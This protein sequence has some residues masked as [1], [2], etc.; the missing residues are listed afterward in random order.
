MRR[1]Y[2]AAVLALWFGVA[3]PSISNARAAPDDPRPSGDKPGEQPGARPGEKPAGDKPGDL[4]KSGQPGAGPEGA[5]PTTTTPAGPTGP[6]EVPAARPAPKA[7]APVAAV[8]ARAVQKE[9]GLFLETRLRGYFNLMIVPLPSGN[10]MYTTAAAPGFVLGYKYRR[11][12]LG[13]AVDFM[14]LEEDPKGGTKTSYSGFSL[15]PVLQMQFFEK[16]RAAV[17]CQFGLGYVYS[18]ADAGMVELNGNGFLV[19]AG[20]GARYYIAPSFAL[21]TEFGLTPSFVWLKA[22]MPGFP[23]YKR[24]DI[25][26]GFYGSL[27]AAV[28]W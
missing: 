6:A 1:A 15:G 9:R 25:Q 19:N 28:V 3:A 7:A 18:E 21:G 16:G 26:L 24:R 17:Y 12:I 20:I 11:I 2:A 10:F 8:K 5:E 23:A 22:S 13:L 27:N 14:V 4:P